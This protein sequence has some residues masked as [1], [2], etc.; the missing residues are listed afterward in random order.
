M[1]KTKLKAALHQ[2]KHDQNNAIS[3]IYENAHFGSGLLQEAVVTIKDLYATIDAPTMASSKFLANFYP[4]YDATV[5]R[6]L[7]AAGAAIVAKTHMD[8][9]A[10]GGTGEHSAWGIINNP[11]DSSRMPGGSSSG[12]VAS[13]SSNITLA[14][15]SDTGNSVRLPASFCGIVGFK[16]S[17]G[18]ISRYG[19]FAFAPSLDTVGFFTHNVSDAIVA[20]RVLFGI[21]EKDLTSKAVELPKLE[22]IKPRHVAFLNTFNRLSPNVNNAYC[23]LKTKLEKDGII[24]DIV[25]IPEHLLQQIDTVYEIISYSEVSSNDA[26]LSAVNFGMRHGGS[27]WQEIMINARSHNLGKMVQRRFTLG[28]YYLLKENQTDIF[29][30]AQKVRRILRDAYQQILE[31]YDV[32]VVP[33]TTIAPKW[34]EGKTTSWVSEYAT[35]S[36]L[37][38]SPS[39]SIPFMHEQNMPVGLLLDTKIYT[40]KKLLS[41]ALYFEK[42]IKGV[43]ND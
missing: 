36:N 34:S 14:L 4:S 42:I 11:L 1:H 43:T 37:I 2:L 35:I 21:D 13:F 17:Y 5:V 24:V 26:N 7:K 27:S 18:A 6:K 3:Y 23:Q 41:H 33:T 31:K 28:A 29:E 20:S 19:M 39:I 15:G 9:L 10:L 25:T 16:P 32:L 38:G 22:L 8:E 30:R 12:A 40:D